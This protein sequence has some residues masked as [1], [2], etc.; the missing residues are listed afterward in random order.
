MS[1]NT[2]KRTR[3]LSPILVL[4]LTTAP[5][6]AVDRKI[7][8][9]G[10][11]EDADKPGKRLNDVTVKVTVGSVVKG[12]SESKDVQNQGKKE[13]GVYKFDLVI[14]DANPVINVV[15]EDGTNQEYLD[16]KIS[17]LVGE[18]PLN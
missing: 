12:S 18:S 16:A 13:S 1:M 3:W 15:F 14:D 2:P 7:T 11:I 4:V 8:L 9:Q 5:A 6:V 10:T 17:L